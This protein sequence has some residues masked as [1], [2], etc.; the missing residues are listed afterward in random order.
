MTR[1]PL[2]IHHLPITTHYQSKGHHMARPQTKQELIEVIL[3]EREKLLK[4]LALLTDEQMTLS[5]ACGEWRTQDILTHLVDWEQRVLGWYQAGLRG[6]TPKTPDEN[7]NWRQL[8]ALNQTIYEKYYDLSPDEA[9]KL[10]E[11]SY[12]ETLA[13]VRAM[14]EDDLFTP[15]RFAW[16]GKS[17]LRDYVNSCTAAHYR[18]A[19]GLVRKFARSL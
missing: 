14:P 11:N 19:R 6:E 4:A 18:W 12:E 15:K 9:R 8:P 13:A 2:T 10:F 16:T 3:S 1:K 17:L 7:Y 5:G